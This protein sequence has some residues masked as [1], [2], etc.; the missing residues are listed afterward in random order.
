MIKGIIMD[1]GGTIDT[2]GVHWAHVLWSMYKKNEIPVSKEQFYTAYV[3]GERT[4]ATKLLVLEHH[5][6]FDVLYIKVREQF[7]FL[8]QKGQELDKRKILHIVE[9]CYRLV[10]DTIRKTGPVVESLSKQYPIVL[11]SNFYGNIDEVLRE[12]KL[13]DL[14]LAVVESAK[15]GVRKPNPEIF[16]LG[17]TQLGLEGDECIVVGDSYSKDMAPAMSLGCQTAWL[18]VTP[19]EPETV[20]TP[21]TIELDD[22]ADLANY[23][24]Q[25]NGKTD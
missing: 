5:N 11:V 25:C 13:S 17:L 14:F 20:T 10:L 4:L 19:W 12:F 24:G 15:A 18:N 2:N 9:D 16:A 1:Y 3:H 23:I 7:A 6:F 8:I 21:A 22:L